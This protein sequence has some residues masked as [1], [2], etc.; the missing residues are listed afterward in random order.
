MPTGEKPEGCDSEAKDRTKP[1]SGGDSTKKPEPASD[2]EGEVAQQ[3][4]NAD[5]PKKKDGKK[6][7][8]G[9]KQKDEESEGEKS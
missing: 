3:E 6:P 7:K 8:D 4:A 5:Q 1:A 9:K 2:A